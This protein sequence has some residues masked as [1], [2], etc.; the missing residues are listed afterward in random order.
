MTLFIVVLVEFFEVPLVRKVH[1][2][3]FGTTIRSGGIT[4][5]L[6]PG[7][8]LMPKVSGS[9]EVTIGGHYDQEKPLPTG[10]LIFVGSVQT[11]NTLK[12]L[13]ENALAQKSNA[14]FE[15]VNDRVSCMTVNF[16]TKLIRKCRNEER[17]VEIGYLGERARWDYFKPQFNKL[18]SSIN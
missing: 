11:Q 6:L 17:R 15:L 9:D 14:T 16:A 1:E 13:Y 8:F 10:S 7:Y 18:V 3:R 12:K 4:S 2:W 5:E